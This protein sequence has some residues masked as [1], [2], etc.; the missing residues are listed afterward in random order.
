MTDT[1]LT[2]HRATGVDPDRVAMLLAAND[3]PYRDVHESPALFF[4]ARVDGEDVGVGGLETYGDAGLLRSVVVPAVHRGRGY[5]SRLRAALEAEARDHG[6]ETLYLLTTT[7]AAF[8]AR[9]GY[10]TVERETVPA[11]I[12]AT[13]EFD[14]LCP[15]SAVCMRKRLR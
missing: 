11:R 15:D 13:T 4:L 6:V 1:S 9:H 10:E 12:R 5:G 14:D 8:F 2:L 7:A 3:L